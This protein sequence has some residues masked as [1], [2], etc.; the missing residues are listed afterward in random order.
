MIDFVLGIIALVD[1]LAFCPTMG[2]WKDSRDWVNSPIE[3]S[4]EGYKFILSDL[5]LTPDSFYATLSGSDQRIYN[6]Y[7][8]L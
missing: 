8:A 2:M 6:D 4:G 3:K 5:A 7:T 1:L